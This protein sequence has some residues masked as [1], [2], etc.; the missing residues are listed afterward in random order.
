[1]AL[2]LSLVDGT[3]S[4]VIVY[5]WDNLDTA[6]SSPDAIEPGGTEPIAG[7]IQMI[8]TPGG[9]TVK[10]QGSNDGTNWADLNDVAGSAIGLSAAAEGAEFSASCRYLRPLTTGGT[11]DDVD[12][13][14]SLRG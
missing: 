10:L 9:G 4:G 2:V 11:T 8:G 3:P 6:D 7:F 14:I 12:V 5:K 1:M 13:F